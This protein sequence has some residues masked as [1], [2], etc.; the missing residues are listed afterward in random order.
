M[1]QNLKTKLTAPY[2]LFVLVFFFFGIFL[3][4]SNRPA[5][6]KIASVSSKDTPSDVKT[7]FSPFWKAWNLIDE[8]YPDAKKITGQ[9]RLYGAIS[10]LIGSLNDPYSVF[11]TPNEAKIFEEDISGSFGGIGAEVGIRNKIL[12]IISPLKNTPA[13]RAGLKAG[14]KIL[15]INNVVTSDLSIEEAMRLLRGDEGTSVV[16]TIFREGEKD[17][18]EV[19][20]FREIINIP[21]LET[22]K[23][24]D[25]I[26]VIT[27]YSFSGNSLKLF[28]NALKEFTETGSDKLILDLRGNP[29]GYLSS[30]VDM[31]SY[32]LPAGKA[33]VVEDYANG[34]KEKVYRSEGFDIFSDNLKMVIL[35]DNGSAS[36]SEILAGAL[37]DYNVAKLV[38]EQSYGKGSVQEVVDITPDTLLKITIAK[39]LTPSGYSIS[40]KGLTPDY[41][42]KM[43]AKD[44]EAGRDPQ[45]NKAVDLLKNWK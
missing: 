24:S 23:R 28:S 16:L 26:F 1:F 39:W 7:D 34:N 29:G 31:A 21:T 5:I 14:D 11:M 30:A 10:G 35:I 33:V 22:E 9:D 18:R 44:E 32:F 6:D 13:Y 8:K 4:Y 40:E 20:I 3:G 15:K 12:T 19:K 25:G 45:M 36:A 17:T 41:E 27:L 43:T 37:R 38:G 2:I 42:V